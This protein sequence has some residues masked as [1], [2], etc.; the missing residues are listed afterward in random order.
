MGIMLPFTTSAA[1]ER[2]NQLD[3]PL[4]GGDFSAGMM[5]DVVA[6]NNIELNAIAFHTSATTTID[7]SVYSRQGTYEGKETDESKWTLVDSK[8]VDGQGGGKPTYFPFDAP[9]VLLEG[10]KR[11]FYIATTTGPFLRTSTTSA[12]AGDEAYSNNDIIVQVGVGKKLGWDGEVTGST[13]FEGVLSYDIYFFPSISP[14]SSPSS[15]PSAAPTLSSMPTSSPSA[16]PTMTPSISLQPSTTPT[17]APSA[18]PSASPSAFPSVDLEGLTIRS[19]VFKA[20]KDTYIEMGSNKTFGNSSFL[21]VDGN[22]NHA[23]LIKFDIS[24]LNGGT[25]EEPITVYGAKLRLN[26]LRDSEFGGSVSIYYNLDFDEE[27]ANWDS[28]GNWYDLTETWHVGDLGK[29]SE[30]KSY[31]LDILD[32]FRKKPLPSTF[33]V[34]IT[35]DSDDGV[36][37]R[38]REGKNG[39]EKEEFGPRVIFDFAYEPATHAK[40]AETFGTDSPTQS[41]TITK[42]WENNLVPTNATSRYFNYDPS[43]EYGPDKW[44]NRKRTTD[45][46]VWQGLRTDHTTN[47]CGSG[48]RQSPRDVCG[49]TKTSCYETHQIRRNSVS[50]VL[51]FVLTHFLGRDFFFHQQDLTLTSVHN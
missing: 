22:P 1:E 32:A 37:Y 28:D 25:E 16:T 39:V 47:K 30:G 46:D 9:I 19:N 51:M 2:S 31:T 21:L 49:N 38:S 7:M 6:T 50:I 4:V 35:S 8:L 41:P 29:V 34:R 3:T 43:S 45:L 14:T 13:I 42:T 10:D 18:F 11:A 27:G 20:V 17:A 48:S 23:T 5:F 40:L 24:S 15:S 36:R 44:R 33:S 26:A 12:T